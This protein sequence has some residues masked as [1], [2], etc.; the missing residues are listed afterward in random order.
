MV[1]REKTDVLQ[2]PGLILGLGPVIVLNFHQHNKVKEY[3][4]LI[5]H[6]RFSCKTNTKKASTCFPKF[7]LGYYYLLSVKTDCS[8]AI[9]VQTP[10][11]ALKTLQEWWKEDMAPSQTVKN[12]SPE[13]LIRWRVYSQLAEQSQ[14]RTPLGLCGVWQGVAARGRRQSSFCQLQDPLTARETTVT[15][16]GASGVQSGGGVEDGLVN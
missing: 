9:S 14:T 10:C 16:A 1:K 5:R 3:F 2:V 6:W 7:L 8:N 11:L 13:K 4:S 12:Q 15:G